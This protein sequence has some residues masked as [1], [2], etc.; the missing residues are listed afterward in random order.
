MKTTIEIAKEEA[1]ALANQFLKPVYIFTGEDRIVHAVQEGAGP[2]PAGAEKIEPCLL[3][4]K[5]YYCWT[6]RDGDK[7]P[8]FVRDHQTVYYALEDGGREVVVY[9]VSQDPKAVEKYPGLDRFLG[10]GT[11]SRTVGK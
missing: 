4:G 7:T 2:V 3:T 1:Q 8:H 11:Y 5:R 6:A 10:I 9:L